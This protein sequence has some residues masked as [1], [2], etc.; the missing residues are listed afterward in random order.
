[1]KKFNAIS[2]LVSLF[3]FLSVNRPSHAVNAGGYAVQ[4]PGA[5][6]QGRANCVVATIDDASAVTFNPARLVTFPGTDLSLGFTAHDTHTNYDSETGITDST[7]NDITYTPNFHIASR[8]GLEKWGFGLGINFPQGTVTNWKTTSPLRFIATKTELAVMNVNP[9]VAFKLNESL[10][11][12]FGLDYYNA[13]KV[14]MKNQLDV[15]TINAV[16]GA[17]D[18]APEGGQKLTGDG[19]DLG[20]DLS[21]SGSLEDR[22]FFGATF[23]KGANIKVDGDIEL[24]NLSGASALAFGG[25]AYKTGGEAKVY[26]PDQLLLGYGYKLSEKLVVELDGEWNRWSTY[27]DL[28]LKFDETDPTRL[29]ILNTGNPKPKN[30]ENSWAVGIGTE[31]QWLEKLALR[32]GYAFVDSPIPN[33]TF[34][35][36]IPDSDYHM[37]TFGLGTSVKDIKLDFAAQIFRLNDRHIDNVPGPSS[38]LDGDG[39]YKSNGVFYSMNF[40]YRFGKN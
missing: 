29:A 35:A 12:G 15:A 8:F 25:T 30:W 37:F 38:G 27:K 28:N 22:H 33:S 5:R 26:V 6:A 31:Y 21:V 3:L 9:A 16:L 14:N 20:F 11:I 39:T 4:V 19:S 13:R 10:S 17:P 24:T 2:L 40:G 34:E 18:A 32:G 23:R 36:S 1:M 7:D